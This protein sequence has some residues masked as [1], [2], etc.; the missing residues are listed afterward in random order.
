[1][2]GK[3]KRDDEG[4]DVNEFAD[5]MWRR[6]ARAAQDSLK[7]QCRSHPERAH[8]A[9]QLIEGMAATAPSPDSGPKMHPNTNGIMAKMSQK[10]KKAILL[11]RVSGIKPDYI[12]MWKCANKDIVEELFQCEF[13]V[14]GNH[15]WPQGLCHEFGMMESVLPR[16]ADRC[17]QAPFHGRLLAVDPATLVNTAKFD[18]QR[19]GIWA[20]Y[21]LTQIAKT[22]ILH[23]PS[24]KMAPIPKTLL[25]VVNNQWTV[26]K[27]WSDF[28]AAMV[29]ADG[30]QNRPINSFFPMKDLAIDSADWVDF[31][32]R[33]ARDIKEGAAQEQESDDA[34]MMA[35]AMNIIRARAD[36]SL[37][38]NPAA[39]ATPP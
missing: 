38:A 30:F 29:D 28:E 34:C 35:G 6:T 12:T 31:A 8:V 2:S 9:H 4:D 7:R 5:K 23:K 15:A 10:M 39:P 17:Q 26:A 22:H 24:G 33:A 14:S 27:N 36:S 11:K 16:W 13:S 1:M 32:N 21:P 19:H 20:Y 18:W 37:G 3:R 25:P